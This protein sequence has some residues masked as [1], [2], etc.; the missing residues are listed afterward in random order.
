MTEELTHVV[1]DV[2]VF[3]VP[4]ETLPG[5][6]AVVESELDVFHRTV[7][8]PVEE[9]V[10]RGRVWKGDED[11]GVGVGGGEE[12]RRSSGRG[13]FRGQSTSGSAEEAS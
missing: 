11:D 5:D 2:E 9:E 6:G 3:D 8:H 1:A 7:I 13:G 4:G 12:M 10:E